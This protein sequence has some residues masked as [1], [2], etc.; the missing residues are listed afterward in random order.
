MRIAKLVI[1]LMFSIVTSATTANLDTMLNQRQKLVMD[2]QAL[3]DS[4][5]Q[6]TVVKQWLLLHQLELIVAHDDSL[7]QHTQILDELVNMQGDSLKG[8]KIRMANLASDI[9]RLQQRTQNDMQ[10]MLIMKIVL[11]SLLL[12]IL[13][14]LYFLFVHKRKSVNH[15]ELKEQIKELEHANNKAQAELNQLKSQEYTPDEEL[16]SRLESKTN[17]VNILSDKIMYLEEDN[18][19][20]T[21]QIN[22][23]GE[24]ANNGL[25]ENIQQLSDDRNQMAA[26]NAKLQEELVQTKA[27]N[28]A[29]LRK[30]NKLISDLSVVNE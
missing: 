1:L 9:D 17:Q 11:A 20:L 29:I 3:Q 23:M 14:L 22:Q 18:R 28:E 6:G 15:S 5:I 27:K 26:L 19:K 21:D 10:M 30:I 24:G 4:V 16:N 25:P 13:V 7:I 12:I 2:Y 8:N